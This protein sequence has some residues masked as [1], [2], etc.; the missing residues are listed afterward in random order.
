MWFCYGSR[1]EFDEDT[2]VYA[3]VLL[4]VLGLERVLSGLVVSL[5]YGSMVVCRD[6]IVVGLGL[7]DVSEKASCNVVYP[8]LFLHVQLCL[9]GCDGFFSRRR[10]CGDEFGLDS[11]LH[12]EEGSRDYFHYFH[13]YADFC[14]RIENVR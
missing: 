2:A 5:A 3:R 4:L 1:S 6:V 10:S 12:A 9:L 13:L 11:L 8:V 14:N 7:F